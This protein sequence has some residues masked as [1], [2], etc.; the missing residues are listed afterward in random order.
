MVK[1]L[2]RYPQEVTRGAFVCIAP[3][4]HRAGRSVVFTYPD[5]RLGYLHLL[6]GYKLSNYL[7]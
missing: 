7:V 6:A 4:Q 3:L 1:P 2:A 5:T